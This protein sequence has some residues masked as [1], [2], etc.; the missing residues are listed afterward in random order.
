MLVYTTGTPPQDSSVLWMALTGVVNWLG[1]YHQTFWFNPA[2]CRPV[3]LYAFVNVHAKLSIHTR[4][5]GRL[6]AY[7]CL[8]LKTLTQWSQGPWY[9]GT[10]TCHQRPHSSVNPSNPLCGRLAS[11][12]HTR[13]GPV[14]EMH[15]TNRVRR[16]SKQWGSWFVVIASYS[17]L[18]QQYSGWVPPQRLYLVACPS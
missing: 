5:S 10:V 1:W 17:L 16:M 8:T 11:T 6:F 7:T 4:P 18:F 14:S 2:D 12:K 13:F 3:A 9:G 15:M